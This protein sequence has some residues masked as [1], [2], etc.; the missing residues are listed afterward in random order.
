[1]ICGS[2]WCCQRDLF[3][4]GGPSSCSKAAE[5][6]DRRQLRGECPHER[7][8]AAAVVGQSPGDEN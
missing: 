6:T 4:V 7:M 5:C 3:T 2:R 1:M 8:I